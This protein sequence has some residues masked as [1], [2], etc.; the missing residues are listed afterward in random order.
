ME[1]FTTSLALVLLACGLTGCNGA[2]WG[3]LMVLGV[4]VGIFFSTLALGRTTPTA[5]A[6]ASASHGPHTGA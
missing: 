6:S 1:R 4:T 5:S 3:N 2:L